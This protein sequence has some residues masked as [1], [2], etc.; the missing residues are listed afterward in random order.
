MGCAWMELA[1][2]SESESESVAVVQEPTHKE[3]FQ[4]FWIVHSSCY[5]IP[6]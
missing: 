1:M 3:L 5:W 2:E 6:H 4:E